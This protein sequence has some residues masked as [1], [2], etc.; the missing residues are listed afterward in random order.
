MILITGASGKLGQLITEQALKVFPSEEIAVSV[1]NASKVQHLADKGITIREADFKK[2]ETLSSAF[3]GIT[4]L[5]VVSANG[6]GQELVDAH[7]NVINAAKESGV[8]R[9]IYT[10]QIGSAAQSHFQPMV[11]HYNTEKL[12]EESGLNFVSSRHGFY[13]DSGAQFF[14]GGL[15]D[16]KL[17]LPKDGPVNWTSHEDLSEGIVKILQDKDFSEK[18][19]LLT[20]ET[21]MTMEEIAHAYDSSIERVVISDDQYRE[22]LDN[23]PNLPEELKQM[24]LDIFHASVDGDFDKSSPL[25]KDLL[26]REPKDIVTF[27]KEHK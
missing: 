8:E 20:A 21:A 5:I 6:Q 16:G 25:L 10:S 19:P 3:E 4:Q 2:P 12:L 1:R 24:F 14:F 27:L 26:G 23:V 17:Y 18:Y 13:A 9:L 7:T 22:A 15:H 11:D